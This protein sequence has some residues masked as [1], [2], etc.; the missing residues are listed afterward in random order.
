MALSWNGGGGK[1]RRGHLPVLSEPLQQMRSQQRDVLDAL[2]QRRKS[3]A[4]CAQQFGELGREAAGADGSAQL[5]SGRRNHT[6]ARPA[7]KFA[8]QPTLRCSRKSGDVGQEECA[9]AIGREGAGRTAEKQLRV[10]LLKH[11][12]AKL[13]HGR[14]CMQGARHGLRSRAL[15]TVYNGGTEV[16][17]DAANLRPHAR[18]CRTG[19]KQSL[20]TRMEACGGRRREV[21]EV[22]VCCH[23]PHS[24]ACEAGS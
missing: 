13:A 1:R 8:A 15:F 19:P 10:F 14:E 5:R 18:N 16:R 3:D 4:D 6:E 20:V 12:E 9:F 17:S 7:A 2:T 21:E 23:T 11:A 24:S 22:R